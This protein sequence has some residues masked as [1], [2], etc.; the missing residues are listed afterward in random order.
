MSGRKSRRPGVYSVPNSA[1]FRI[2]YY[3]EHDELIRCSA[4]TTVEREAWK[5][6]ERRLKEVEAARAKG[7]F[8]CNVIDGFA[9][10]MTT[11]TLKPNS[12]DRYTS[13]QD[14]W[15]EFCH[16]HKVDDFTQL[17]KKVVGQ[18][19]DWRK[20]RGVSRRRGGGVVRLDITEATIRRDLAF[21]SSVWYFLLD[22]HDWEDHMP[23]YPA[24]KGQKKGLKESRKRVRFASPEEWKALLDACTTDQQRRILTL[25]VETGLREQELCRLLWSQVD[26]PRRQ[27][28]LI[29]EVVDTKSDLPRVIPLSDAAMS[30]LSDTPRHTRAQEVFWHDEGEPF[31]RMA[32][33]WKAVRRRSGVQNFTYHDIRHTFATSFLNN[34]GDIA[35]LKEILGHSSVQV[36]ERYAFM[37]TRRMHEEVSRIDKRVR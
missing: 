19:I 26:L 6:L 9:L 16:Q 13:S 27:I 35:V 21:L 14:H 22:H 18:F 25:A 31:A 3:D 37:Q 4:E 1:N 15:V 30:A 11:K 5:L 29:P 28:V 10:F 17:T 23:P 7:V 34:G 2:K 8:R 24:S 32:N 12:L 20:L 36:T 33:W